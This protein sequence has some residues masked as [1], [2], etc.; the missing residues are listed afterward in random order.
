M[1][2]STALWRMWNED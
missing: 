1:D 2:A